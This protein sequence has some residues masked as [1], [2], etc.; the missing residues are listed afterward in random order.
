MVRVAAQS[1]PVFYPLNMTA[2]YSLKKY[3]EP[4]KNAYQS[5]HLEW[6]RINRPIVYASGN[7]PLCSFPDVRKANGLTRFVIN[8]IEWSGYYANRISSAGRVINAGGVKKYI[9]GQTKRGTADIHAIIKGE[10][11]SIEIKVGKDSMSEYQHEEEKRIKA[12]GGNY[13][14]VSDADMFITAINFIK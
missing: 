2:T 14:V 7:V 4:W 1:I 9:P 3:K 13:M 8:I 6:Y 12:A 11:Y 5:A 10:H